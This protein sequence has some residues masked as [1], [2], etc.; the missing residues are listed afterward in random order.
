M[1]MIL[2]GVLWGFRFLMGACIFSFL[3]VVIYRLPLGESV[4]YGRSHCPG[5]GR[6]LTA[7]ELIPC[8]SYLLQR[9]KCS[10]C[11]MKIAA[12]YFIVE[13][14]GGAAFVYCSAF[15]GCEG[16]LISL[17]GALAFAYLGILTV[18]AWIDWKTKIIYDRFHIGII[19]TGIASM[20]LYPERVPLERLL[21]VMVVALPML[22]L[23]LL[24]EGAFG[25]GDI[26]LM[27]SSGFLLGWRSMIPA[28]FLGLLTG[29]VYCVWM[30]WRKK[31]GRKDRFAFGPFLA[32]GLAVAYF[33]GDAI[34]AW[35]L[36]VCGL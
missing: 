33:Y 32:V 20:P 25:G 17:K 6:P 29:G 24:V 14:L 36:S 11:G 12:Q 13:C 22:L 9:G 27:A 28:I 21:G 23:A 15:F 18:V 7:R 5:C 31:L 1:I 16:R 3:N 19:I 30:L 2:E 8:V 10:G 4:V 35:Y 34:T 26:K